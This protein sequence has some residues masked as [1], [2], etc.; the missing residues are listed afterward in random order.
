MTYE[1]EEPLYFYSSQTINHDV[2]KNC[3]AG[4]M[5]SV[6]NGKHFTNM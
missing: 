5:A 6:S 4:T 3:N 1:K 2:I